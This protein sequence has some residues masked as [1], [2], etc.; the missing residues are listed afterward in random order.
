MSTSQ[1]LEGLQFS[2]EMVPA[3]QMVLAAFF[4]CLLVGG[5]DESPR[6]RNASRRVSFPPLCYV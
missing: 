1:N 4:E 2:M 6:A 3:M 5:V